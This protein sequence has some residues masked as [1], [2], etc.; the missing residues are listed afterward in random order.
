MYVFMY[1]FIYFT[2]CGILPF[3][4]L[5]KKTLLGYFK[6]LGD[7]AL[8]FSMTDKSHKV[9]HAALFFCPPK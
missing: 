8:L 7:S 5:K 1:V 9:F 6:S 3:G 2:Q 4:P